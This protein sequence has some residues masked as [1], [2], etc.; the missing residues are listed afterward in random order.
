MQQRAPLEERACRLREVRK[1]SGDRGCGGRAFPAGERGPVDKSVGRRCAVELSAHIL[2]ANDDMVRKRRV[3]AAPGIEKQRAMALLA[4]MPRRMHVAREH[5]TR[6][7][8]P[9]GRDEIDIARVAA[10]GACTTHTSASPPLGRVVAPMFSTESP[11]NVTRWPSVQTRG[12]TMSRSQ[13]AG[14]QCSASLS[15]SKS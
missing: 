2:R 10:G 3:C 9:G 11:F 13:Y 6:S 7:V 1:R 12:L 15:H 8:T 4:P 14:V 5:E